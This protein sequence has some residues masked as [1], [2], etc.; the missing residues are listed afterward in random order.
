LW[1]RRCYRKGVEVMRAGDTGDMLGCKSRG[2]A[3]RSF[4][5]A[6]LAGRSDAAR[7]VPDNGIPAG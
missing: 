6:L 5:L 1:Q 2:I 4:A 3:G 7:T